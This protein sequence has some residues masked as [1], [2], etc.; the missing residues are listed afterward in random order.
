MVSALAGCRRV[1][2]AEIGV[3]A[4]RVSAPVARKVFVRLGLDRSEFP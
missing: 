4:G 1:N 2:P 3:S